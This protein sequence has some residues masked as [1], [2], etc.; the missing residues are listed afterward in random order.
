MIDFV[1]EDDLRGANRKWSVEG[2]GHS[3]FK[4]DWPKSTI[5]IDLKDDLTSI[6]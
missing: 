4:K 1:F 3:S 6:G 5:L 2:A